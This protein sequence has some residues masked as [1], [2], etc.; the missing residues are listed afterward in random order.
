MARIVFVV[1]G[2][3]SGKSAYAQSLA[4]SAMGRHVYVATAPVLDDEMDA[5][6]AAH[7]AAR[8]GGLWQ[9][10]V[11]CQTELVRAFAGARPQDILLVDSLGMWVNN[12]LHANPAFDENQLT[13]LW[14]K[15]H[16]AV[17]AHPAALTVLVG[18][19]VGC[20]LIGATSLARRFGDLNG[21]LNALVAADA[22]E[23]IFMSC[24][25]PLSLK[26]LP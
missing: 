13:E 22:V 18:D 25:L 17:A 7:Q 14:R 4:E 11:E 2:N 9:G 20:G 26:K 10:T 19:E 6:I 15:T 16:L 8:E 24:G 1:G 5:R 3:R 12:L 21:K 23:V